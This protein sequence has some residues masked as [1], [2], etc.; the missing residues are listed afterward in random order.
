MKTKFKTMFIGSLLL[1]TI[2]A[3][4]A[5]SQIAALPA[6]SSAGQEPQTFF[7]E[8]GKMGQG[9]AR[10]YAELKADGSPVRIGI[11]FTPG[12]LEGLP[13]ELNTQDS[14]RCFDKN[15]DGAIHGHDECVGDY[16]LALSMPTELAQRTDIP[17]QW[18]SVNW[19]PLGHLPPAAPAWGVSHFDF[20]FYTLKEEAVQAIRPGTCG[21]LMDCDD[22]AHAQTPIPAQYLPANYKM[23]AAVPAMGQHLIDPTAPEL[24]KPPQAEFTQSFLYGAYDSHIIFYEPMIA[25][26]FLV[27]QSDKCE[28]FPLP[29]AW[30]T[31]GYYPTR[32]CTRYVAERKEYTVSLEDFVQRE[33][34]ADT[35]NASAS[36]AQPAL[37]ETPTAGSDGRSGVE[38]SDARASQTAEFYCANATVL[39][40]CATISTTKSGSITIQIKNSADGG[41][42]CHL[43]IPSNVPDRPPT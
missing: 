9:T 14:R 38:L 7:G 10:T 21:H 4:T 11:V 8:S 26:S 42:D 33:A 18:A 31:S 36:Q 12:L 39:R 17:F 35:G 25:H 16:E 5:C 2:I 15:G 23:S 41:Q 40:T 1:L 22:F 13:T 32:Y 28:A 27:S 43:A 29:E 34:R 20:H 30:E 3:G 24:A 6:G 37:A 19:N